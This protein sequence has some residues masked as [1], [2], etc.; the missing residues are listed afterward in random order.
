MP[1]PTNLNACCPVVA[2]MS[3][4][5]GVPLA[6]LER[7]DTRSHSRSIFVSQLSAV[8]PRTVTSRGTAFHSAMLGGDDPGAGISAGSPSFA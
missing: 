5:N 3:I 1:G 7:H 4:M 8:D 6:G 2:P